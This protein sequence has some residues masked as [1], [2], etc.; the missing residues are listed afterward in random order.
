MF[1]VTCFWVS[2]NGRLLNS[3]EFELLVDMSHKPC[4]QELGYWQENENIDLFQKEILFWSHTS[5][6]QPISSQF[7]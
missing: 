6:Y 3:V 5:I 2:F 7:W 4:L 1:F